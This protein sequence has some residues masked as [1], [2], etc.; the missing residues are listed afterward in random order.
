MCIEKYNK[1]HKNA[2]KGIIMRC[3][4][5]SIHIVKCRALLTWKLYC[6]KSNVQGK[7]QLERDR[8]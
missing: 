2:K 8:E 6:N 7:K 4:I 1:K 3:E 5:K